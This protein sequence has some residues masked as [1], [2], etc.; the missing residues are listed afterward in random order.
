MNFTDNILIDNLKCGGCQA[1]IKNALHKIEGVEK[2][3]I[4]D[5]TCHV[6]VIHDEHVTRN[7]LTKTLKSL[8]YPET[9]TTAGIEKS[10]ANAKSYISCAIGKMSDDDKSGEN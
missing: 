1:S 5:K 8:G 2:V 4:N 9:G 3:L 7:M 10:L 6:S